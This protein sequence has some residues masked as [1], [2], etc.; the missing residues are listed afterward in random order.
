[1]QILSAIMNQLFC[2]YDLYL[3]TTADRKY[4][5]NGYK[6][7]YRCMKSLKKAILRLSSFIVLFS[8]GAREQIKFANQSDDSFI[9]LR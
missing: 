9:L 6:M 1:M 5:I 7:Y 3:C 2:M 8:F 4:K